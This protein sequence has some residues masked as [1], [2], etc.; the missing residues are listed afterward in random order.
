MRE[1]RDDGPPPRLKGNALPENT[2]GAPPYTTGRRRGACAAR[3]P[4][5]LRA[6]GT[7]LLETFYLLVRGRV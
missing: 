3:A 1:L 4:I 2:P 7:Y 6:H 5:P